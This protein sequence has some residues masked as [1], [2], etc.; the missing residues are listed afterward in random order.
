MGLASGGAGPA[1]PTSPKNSGVLQTLSQSPP[2]SS[3][4][5]PQPALPSPRHQAKG[6]GSL[7]TGCSHILFWHRSHASCFQHPTTRTHASPWSR[8]NCALRPGPSLRVPVS[9]FVCLSRTSLSLLSN[10]SGS[11]IPPALSADC[12]AV[13]LNSVFSFSPL[14]P[15]SLPISACCPGTLPVPDP[16]SL[17]PPAMWLLLCL[18]SW[19]TFP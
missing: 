15:A 1:I 4:P 18:P 11:L 19:R 10:L 5:R 14:L 17:S 9:S 16:K 13:P 6:A 3:T 7:G 2:S 8:P 12:S